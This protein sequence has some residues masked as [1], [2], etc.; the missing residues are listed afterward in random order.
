MYVVA[1]CEGKDDYQRVCIFKQ[2]TIL[3]GTVTYLYDGEVY[4]LTCSGGPRSIPAQA[5][6]HGAEL[7][8]GT[9]LSYPEYVSS[10]PQI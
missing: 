2:L 9:N 7:M 10:I 3:N 6:R 4:S 5:P 8:Q 1:Q